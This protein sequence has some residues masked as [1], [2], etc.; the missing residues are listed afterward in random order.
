MNMRNLSLLARL[1]RLIGAM[2]PEWTARSLKK[3]I[4]LFV[5]G[6][7][8]IEQIRSWFE[9]SDNPGLCR[10][11][12]RFPLISGAIY[13]P[14]IN[15][16]WP[17]TTRLAAIQQHYRLL[18][19]PAQI[20]ARATLNDVELVSFDREYA[21]LRL[22]LDKASWFLRE[23]EIVLNLFLH[24]RRIYSLAFTLGVD[25]GER[26]V[27]VG[28]I[29]GS[30]SEDAQEI[31][32][33]ITHQLFGMRPR[34]LLVSALKFLCIELG[35]IKIWAISTEDRQHNSP[36]FGGSHDEKVLVYYDEV[37]LEHGGAPLGNGFF[38]ILPVVRYKDMSE[39]PSRKR[40]AYRRRYLMLDRVAQD[41]RAAC[42]GHIA[43][44]KA[45]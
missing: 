42:G 31:Y 32:R 38:E 36:Y 40:A 39:I 21:G 13:W 18:G 12:E 23:G 27:F 3:R 14:Y 28:A 29:Q 16:N 9:I 44:F 8:D 20:I 4:K 22:V 35:V 34:D 11:L 37:W 17:R 15:R 33:G 1:C 43:C 41:I 5:D 30:N 25:G 6:A 19:G 26:L 7:A 45:N 10:A 2:H 24:D